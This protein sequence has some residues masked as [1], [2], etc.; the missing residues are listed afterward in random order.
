[1]KAVALTYRGQGT[2]TMPQDVSDPAMKPDSRLPETG[3]KESDH[4]EHRHGCA[5]EANSISGGG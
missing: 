2:N 3:E 4:E 1:M 5:F